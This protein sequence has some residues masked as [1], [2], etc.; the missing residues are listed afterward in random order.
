MKK[1]KFPFWM[2]ITAIL[3]AGVLTSGAVFFLMW[4]KGKPQEEDRQRYTV[5]FAYQDGTVIETKEVTQGKGVFPPELKGQGVFR[6]WS[7]GINNIQRDIEVHPNYY[8]NEEDNLFCFD[9]V[10]VQEGKEFSLD[11]RLRG[12]VSVSAGELILEYDP[13]VLD[14]LGAEDMQKCTVEEETEGTV[15]LRFS[16]EEPIKEAMRFAG[17]RFLAKEKDAY[18]TEVS[19][20]TRNVFIVAQGQELPADHATLNNK[21][22]FMQEVE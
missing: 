8:S 2:Q 6:G 1:A 22:F 12:K 20:K 17:L 13:E 3:L 10:Y 9:S 7:A 14:F 5:T 4:G 11:I 16:S 19:L 21:V 15:M 18:F